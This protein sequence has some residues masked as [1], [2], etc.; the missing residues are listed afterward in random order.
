MEKG[1]ESASKLA[2]WGNSLLNKL[3]SVSRK[4]RK[5]AADKKRRRIAKKEIENSVD[6]IND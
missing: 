2:V 4:R 6:N 3:P 1:K 5:R